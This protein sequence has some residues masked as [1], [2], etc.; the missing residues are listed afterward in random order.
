[1]VNE[2]LLIAAITVAV[3][4]V[5]IVKK[6]IEKM[7]SRNGNGNGH[8]KIGDLAHKLDALVAWHDVRDQNGVPM[9]YFP[10]SII[11][12]QKEMTVALQ[13]ISATQ[14][15]IA[16]HLDHLKDRLDERFD[17]VDRKLDKPA[18]LR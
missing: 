10:R 16:E 9:G 3:G 4:L 8:A 5:E 2:A 17:D 13:S 18:S 6:L 12:T 11:D 15:K 1:M 14:E 7:M